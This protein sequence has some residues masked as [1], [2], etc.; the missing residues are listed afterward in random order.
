MGYSFRLTAS[1]LLYGSSQ[2]QGYTVI[3]HWRK[4]R[5]SGQMHRCSGVNGIKLSEQVIVA[6]VNVDVVGISVNVVTRHIDVMGVNVA[7]VGVNVVI[8]TYML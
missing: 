2:R 6:D 1:D 8:L 4:R 7:V 3:G 5:C